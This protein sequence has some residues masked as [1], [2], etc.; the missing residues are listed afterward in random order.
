VRVA[1]LRENIDNDGDIRVS[2]R[3][4]IE[5]IL[6]ERDRLYESRFKAGEVAVAA[7]LSAQEKAVSAAFVASEK[8]VLKA[9]EAQKEYNIRSNEFRGQLDDQ[10]KTL[11]PRLESSALL[12]ALEE[13]IGISGRE[14]ALLRETLA[15]DSASNRETMLREIALLRDSTMKEI[16][17]LRDSTMK[18]ITGLRESRSESSGKFA[19]ANTLWLIGIGALSF[20]IAIAGLFISYFK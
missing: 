20:F 1:I 7:A 6:D 19:G 16:S 17:L 3:E 18:E 10:A 8:A 13:K 2:I 4:F 9:E 14:V 15:T 5:R 12:R 11:M